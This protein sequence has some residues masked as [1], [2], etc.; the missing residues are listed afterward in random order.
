MRFI[1]LCLFL[2]VSYEAYCS[3]LLIYEA[4]KK[5]IELTEKD[6]ETLEIGEISTTKYVVGG[7]LGT[8]PIGFG[9]GHAVQGRW[10]EDGKIFTFGELGSLGVVVVGAIGCLTRANEDNWTCSGL[11]QGLIVAGA[12]G[13]LSFRIWEIVDVWAIPPSH[14]SRF[15]KLEKYINESK[16]EPETKASLDLVPILSPGNGTGIGLKLL[17]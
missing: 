14:N 12:I 10:S 16:A 13:F 6:K 11:D 17:F 9:L 8:Y 15:K 4:Q 2:L 5:N 3:S 7:I 1:C